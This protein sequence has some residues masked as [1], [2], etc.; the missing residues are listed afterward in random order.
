MI[1]VKYRHADNFIEIGYLCRELYTV[2]MT[3]TAIFR[4]F[5]PKFE[6]SYTFRSLSLFSASTD[7]HK[8]FGIIY[9]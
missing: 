9:N 5:R 6:D 4:E 8:I 2:N 3:K 1:Y 7:F